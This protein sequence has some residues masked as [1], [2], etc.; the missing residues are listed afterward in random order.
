[1]QLVRP[2]VLEA[3][4]GA[5]FASIL[6]CGSSR[7]IVASVLL[8]VSFPMHLVHQLVESNLLFWKLLPVHR[9][10]ASYAVEAPIGGFSHLFWWWLLGFAT[11]CASCER[12]HWA[13]M[14][15]VHQMFE[16][17]LFWKLLLVHKQRALFC[18]G[19]SSTYGGLSDLFWWGLGSVATRAISCFRSSCGCI[20]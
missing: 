5:S 19:C 14:H 13:L 8:V 11:S 1:M 9:Q 7:W 16:S 15:L 2:F 10:G 20:G 12:N 6:C 18:C 17:K 3:L 4:V